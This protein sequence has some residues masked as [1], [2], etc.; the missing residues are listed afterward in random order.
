MLHRSQS[1][2]QVWGRPP[3]AVEDGGREEAEERTEE[4]WRRPHQSHVLC[5][6][7]WCLSSRAAACHEEPSCFVLVIHAVEFSREVG[8][9]RKLSK[10]TCRGLNM[11]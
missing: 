6:V 7:P 2:L 4:V 8:R 11:T 10:G 9:T 5:C 3:G 1:A